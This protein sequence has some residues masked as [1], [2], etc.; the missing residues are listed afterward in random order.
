M[1]IHSFKDFSVDEFIEEE[2]F[3]SWVIDKDESL[4][5]FWKKYLSIYPSQKDN[6]HE[7]KRLLEVTSAY[8]Q[9]KESFINTPSQDFKSKLA[10]QFSENM[11]QSKK[12]FLVPKN[13]ALI[14]A[15]ILFIV[16]FS[17]LYLTPQDEN[18]T[19]AIEYATNKAEWKKIELP[20]GSIVELNANS[21]LS[22]SGEW[23]DGATRIVWLKGEAFFKVKKI[24]S[25]NVKFTVITK[26]LEVDVL[27]T[28]FSVNTRNDHT[29]VFLEEGNITLDMQGKIEKIKPG[30]F[31]SY[32]QESKKII[33]RYKETE[34]IHSKWKDGVL[35][36]KDASMKDILDE[37]ETIYGI[38]LIVN[39]KS[40]LQKVGS[41]AIPVD[42]IEMATSILE[43]VLNVNMEI[44]GKQVFIN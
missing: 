23:K 27:G 18:S 1:T 14:A 36:I 30:E 26:D 21:Q 5:Y 31:I 22:L 17:A 15:S 2:L 12:P 4:D 3:R 10:H 38:D 40:L 7:A 16:G 25:T 43:R 28:K 8:Y 6:L 39:D 33:D 11:A 9:E 35:K 20:D 41:V 37:V 44:K 29:E 13:L 24:P 19:T 32:S 42:D 34:E